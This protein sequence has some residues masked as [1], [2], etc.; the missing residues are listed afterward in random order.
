MTGIAILFHY[1][2]GTPVGM[3][4]LLLNQYARGF[5]SYASILFGVLAGYV[6]ALLKWTPFVLEVRDLWPKQIIDLGTVRNPLLWM[7]PFEGLTGGPSSDL[8]HA[9]QRETL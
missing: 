9:V 1:A 6:V 7:A 3:V 8:A 2:F 4:T 5:F